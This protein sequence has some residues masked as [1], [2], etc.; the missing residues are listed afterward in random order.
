M[1]GPRIY[2]LFPTVVGDVGAW[3]AELPR[4]RR[5]E[6]DWVFVNPFHA[7]GFSGSLYAVQ[8]YYRLNPLF[9]NGAS[10]D[11][12]LAGFARAARA[13]GL[14][15]M[16]DLV[17]NHTAKDSMLAHEHPDWFVRDDAGQLVSPHAV[18]PDDPSRITV[19]GD[20][21]EIDYRRRPER[22][23]IVDY[24][25]KLVTHF[26]GL[27]FKGFRCD[28]A[29]KLPAEV[30]AA[31]IQSARAIEPEVIFAAESLGCTREQVEALRPAGFDFLFN[32]SKWWDFEQ[33]WLLELHENFR[34]IAPSIAFPESHD[35]PRLVVDLERAGITDPK[36]IEAAYRQRYMFAALASSGV[37]MPIGF[38][39]G[40]ARPLDVVHTHWNDR[41]PACFDLSPFIA[42]VNRMKRDTPALNVEGPQT[43]FP[44]EGDV[45]VLRRTTDMNEGVVFSLIN[46]S[47][48]RQ[49]VGAT[50]LAGLREITPGHAANW[51]DREAVLAP[52]EIRAFV[53]RVIRT[54]VSAR[55]EQIVIQNVWPEIDCGRFA[56]KRV[57]GDELTVG[58]DIFREGHGRIGAVLKLRAE[59]DGNWREIAMTRVNAGLDLWNAAVVLE[60]NT[61][62]RYT[63]EAWPDV[64]ESWREEVEKKKAAGQNVD[65]ELIE[66]EALQ[67]DRFGRRGAVT[68]AHELELVVDRERA[69][70][71]AWYEMVPRSQGTNPT[72]SATF[73]EAARRLPEIAA[74]GF[75]VIYMPPI[76]PIGLT[77]RKGPNNSLI[78][79][80]DAPGSL[81]AIGS[82]DGGHTAVHPDLGTLD[83][84]R[85]FVAECRRLNM[86][87][88]LDF[89]VQASPDH[90]WIKEHPEWFQFR[91]DGTI[92]F[93]ENPPKKYEDIVNFNFDSSARDELETALI[94]VIRFWVA[95]DV[96]IFRVDNPHTKPIPFWERLI[97]EVQTEHPDVLFLSEA[98]TRPRVMEMLAKV[99]FTQSYTY[100]TWRNTK[101]EL[102]SYARELTQSAVKE[103]LR[104]NFFTNTPDINPPFLQTGGRAAFQIRVTLA[105]TLSTV[106]GIYNG[107]E[108][109]EGRAVPGTEDYANSEKY[110]YKVWDWDRPGNIK[111]F[112][113]RLNAIRRDNRA[114]QLFDNLE[115]LPA[116]DDQVLFYSKATPDGTNVIYIALTLDPHTVRAAEVKFP[117]ADEFFELEDLLGGHP[118]RLSGQR[119]T[120][121]FDPAE[122]PVFIFRRK[123]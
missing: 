111:D 9:A 66:G 3:C 55:S 106:Y 102:T 78:A 6:F 58:A 88:A 28:A 121:R 65:L 110:Q 112:I 42:D 103:Y 11:E 117:I 59:G 19:W 122:A 73:A 52:F 48:R 61:R 95:Q 33:P 75:D 63:V 45:V 17:I 81:Y 13:E 69:R 93:A 34:H 38:E 29:Y 90:P 72:R 84:F 120:L 98:F 77:N 43:K 12:T 2:N 89:A 62:Y 27:G 8:D 56:A 5:M 80:P 46:R 7:P 53:D 64:Y 114:L 94:D 21:A 4:I 118:R 83:D 60:R 82:P 25:K 74:M 35:T 18:D 79:G 10:H 32:S 119:Q 92:K 44:M 54:P 97:R 40:W 99:G 70:F 87:V 108:L 107:F 116:G 115:F 50:V 91:P 37:M 22:S 26:V 86:E 57:V 51:G 71:A 105:A 14:G 109:C 67:A 101:E 123:A 24:W 23:A 85:A 16:M 30:W 96:K 15:V 113:A 104:P 31:V 76:H 36:E 39:F 49:T 20:L 100:F 1:T 68:Y 47:P 41:E